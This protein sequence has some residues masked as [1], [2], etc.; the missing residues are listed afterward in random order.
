MW[1]KYVAIIIWISFSK[2]KA[3]ERKNEMKSVLKNNLLL[4]KR[5]R[6]M[7]EMIGLMGGEVRY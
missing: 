3:F 7:T 2:D 4:R 5:L 1:Y 6:V